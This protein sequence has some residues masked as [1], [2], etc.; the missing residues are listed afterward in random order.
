MFVGQM[1]IGRYPFVMI[2]GYAIM[3][4]MKSIEDIRTSERETE[5]MRI[6]SEI[7]RS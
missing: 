2:D 6:L 1:C 7:M 3:T 4:A 5:R